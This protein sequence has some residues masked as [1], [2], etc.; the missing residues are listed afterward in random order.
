MAWLPILFFD[1][2]PRQLA[3]YASYPNVSTRALGTFDDKSVLGHGSIAPFAF[4][5]F[6]RSPVRPWMK[7]ILYS[8]RISSS[9]FV[10]W[11]R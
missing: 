3:T 8:V 9:K 6:S 5:V 10:V 11:C 4:H 2:M 7:T 1:T